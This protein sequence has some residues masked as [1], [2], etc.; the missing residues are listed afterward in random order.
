VL[1]M[2]VLPLP[3]APA[4]EGTRVA[5]AAE[6]RS[7]FNGDGFSDLAVGVP[8]QKVGSAEAAGAVTVLYGSAVGLS[9]G[10]SQLWTEASTGLAGAGAGDRFGWALAAGDFDGDGFSDLAVA[11]PFK[12]VGTTADAGALAVLYGSPSGLGSSGAML[13]TLDASGFGAAG[14]DHFG[15]SLASANLGGVPQDDLAVGIPGHPVGAAS[16]AGAVAVLYG[17]SGGL[18]A[19]G[20]QL[21]TQASGGGADGAE[22]EDAFGAAL[23]AG[24]LGRGAPADL[25]VGAPLEDLEGAGSAGAVEVLYGSPSG[26]TAAGSQ[27]WTQDSAGVG[28]STEAGDEFGGALATGDFGGGDSA[29]LAVGVALEDLGAKKDAGAVQVL[30]GSSTGLSATGSQLWTQDSPGVDGDGEPGDRFGADLAAGDFGRGA[31]SDLAVGVPLEDS[32]RIVDAG[33]VNVLYGSSS[34]LSSSV[35]QVW[36][37]GR[38]GTAGTAE[39][40]DLFGAAVGASNFGRSSHSDL[41]VGEPFEDVGVPEGGAVNV[42]YGS[43]AGLSATEDQL[44]DREMPG[45][46]GGTGGGDLFGWSVA[47][48]GAHDPCLAAGGQPLGGCD[49]VVVGAGDIAMCSSRGDERTA[50]LLDA[51]PGTVIAVGDNAYPHGRAGD[52]R[53]C[54]APS[55]GRHRFRTWPVPGNHDYHTAGASGYFGYF[56]A[57]AGDPTRGYYSYDVGTWHVIALNSNCD[58]IGGCQAGSPE[59]QWLRADL[60]AHPAACTLAYWHHPRFSSGTDH[61]SDPMMQPFWQALYDFGTEIVVGG[62][63]HDYERFAP[64]TPRGDADAAAG[65][66]E[67]VVGTGGASLATLGPSIANSQVGRDDTHGVLQLTL[68]AGSYSW[69]FVS[70]A[71]RSFTD[72]GSQSC[73]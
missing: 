59:E 40:G 45:I 29:D 39:S 52:F 2:A 37:Q 32:G 4:P 21:W 34:G 36:I 51:T 1:S 57:R 49:P 26:L 5:S 12:A 47:E 33:A 70:V 55:W 65:I 48:P 61:G 72:S 63:D 16:G 24:D 22:P 19:G 38:D 17:S 60:S 18:T 10:G 67:F 44:W 62:H 3:A 14:G 7:D 15:W 23:A 56:G 71:G 46:Q 13:W 50:A 35:D 43:A 30:Y 64:Q 9:A 42:M 11:M 8:G 69:K 25:A 31:R 6:P 58:R 66:R 28:G 68:R 54:Y 73:H 41:V 20:S 27:V 53:N